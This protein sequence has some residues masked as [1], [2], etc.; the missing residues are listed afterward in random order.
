MAIRRS[1][2]TTIAA[3]VLGIAAL[4]GLAACGSGDDNGSKGTPEIAAK[5][6]AAWNNADPKA[7]SELFVKDGARY[8]DHAFQKTSN[9]TDG[10]TA[11]AA[12]THQYVHNAGLKVTNSFAGGDQVTLQWTFTGQMEGAPKP[13]SVPAVAVLKM[14]GDKIVSD[15]DYYSVADILKQS[16]LPANM[17]G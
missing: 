15:D 16:G 8:T 10:V 9:G 14:Q 5:W 11:W 1:V 12:R 17:F 2:T 6:D 13:F 7:V 3:S 4:G